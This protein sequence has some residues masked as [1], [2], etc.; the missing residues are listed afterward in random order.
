[1]HPG[2]QAKDMA[3]KHVIIFVLNI[4]FCSVSPSAIEAVPLQGRKEETSLVTAG[5]YVIG[6]TSLDFQ[7]GTD[8][9]T[10]RTHGP[11]NA[12]FIIKVKEKG[13]GQGLKHTC[14]KIFSFFITQET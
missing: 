11:L 12:D 4:T 5:S 14:L 8:R 6:N 10:L 1:M 3:S 7:R 13:T 2:E 9:Q